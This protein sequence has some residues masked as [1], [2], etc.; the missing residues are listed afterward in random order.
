MKHLRIALTSLLAISA[1]SAAAADAPQSAT[2]LRVE[3]RQVLNTSAYG[4]TEDAMRDIRR[5]SRS[6]RLGG[7]PT[8]SI[9]AIR[10]KTAEGRTLELTAKG[11]P[12]PRQG[13]TVQF[14]PQTREVVR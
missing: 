2:V 11:Q 1:F 4:S 8:E 13:E 5:A 10:A 14:N 7:L 9:Y 3:E 6:G 12:A